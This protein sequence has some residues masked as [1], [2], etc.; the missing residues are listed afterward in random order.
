MKILLVGNYLPDAQHS[1]L[2]FG[3]AL[4]KELQK[5]GYE[6]RMTH[7]PPRLGR[8]RRVGSGLE[9]W[10]AY[11]DK[12]VF[13]LPQLKREASWA[14]VVHI[15]DHAYSLYNTFLSGVPRVIT[16]HDLLSVRC[17]LG[18]FKDQIVGWSGRR[19]QR[20]IVR[21]LERASFVGCVSAATRADVLRLTRVPERQT[22]LVYNGYNFAYMPASEAERRKSFKRLGIALGDRFLIHVGSH[23]WYKNLPG[24]VQIFKRIAAFPET[25]DLRLIM[26]VS[27]RTDELRSLA[28]NL[29]LGNRLIILSNIYSEDLRALYS[30]AS[31]LLFP[32]LYEG[33]GWPMIEAQACGCPVFSSNRPPMPEIGGM[34]AVYF[35]PEA[36]DEAAAIIRRYLP[37]AQAMRA[38]GLL[39]A[40][41]FS[42]S[43]MTTAYIGLYSAAISLKNDRST[44][45]ARARG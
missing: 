40:R 27:S 5:A 39:N 21:G 1:M 34:A 31:A 20:M 35:N 43:S 33:F 17:S 36:Y 28:K 22:A 23:V 6:V 12:F 14:D 2:G 8:W 32:S 3:I 42:A 15:C 38:S 29:G 18:E 37:Q 45:N 10:L 41:R 11:F 44:N 24:V 9:K 16:C 26:V 13:F 30:A 25:R 7:P 19:Y 4:G